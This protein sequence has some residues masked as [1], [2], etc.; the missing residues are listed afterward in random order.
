MTNVLTT[1]GPGVEFI[2]R[3]EKEFV[4][5]VQKAIREN[6]ED[7][8][9]FYIALKAGDL[10]CNKQFC[11]CRCTYRYEY[12]AGNKLSF[13]GTD[14]SGEFIYGVVEGDDEVYKLIYG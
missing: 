3:T 7:V 2:A 10:C 14:I 12:E 8:M 9:V 5:L 4:T 1:W 6:R 13:V 11:P